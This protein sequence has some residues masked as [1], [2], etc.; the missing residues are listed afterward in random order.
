MGRTPFR[1]V[2]D[3]AMAFIGAS[4]LVGCGTTSQDRTFAAQ[5][6]AIQISDHSRAQTLDTVE[7]TVEMVREIRCEWCKETGDSCCQGRKPH[8]EAGGCQ[9]GGAHAPNAGGPCDRPGSYTVRDQF[10]RETHYKK[11]GE[12]WICGCGKAHSKS[13]PVCTQT[14][15]LP[16][17]PE[18]G[19]DSSDGAATVDPTK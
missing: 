17:E 7:R 18:G 8:H 10:I 2:M 11:L 13:E 12:T 14:R 5:D 4:L 3:V 1:I 15:V 6:K 19:D 16:A 9:H